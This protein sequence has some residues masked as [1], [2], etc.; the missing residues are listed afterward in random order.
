MAK[1]ALDEQRTSNGDGQAEA[2]GGEDRVLPPT[3]KERPRGDLTGAGS[4]RGAT[5]RQ[6]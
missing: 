3:T 5:P 1:F 6:S 2:G 4:R